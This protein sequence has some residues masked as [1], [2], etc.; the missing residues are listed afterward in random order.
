M[1]IMGVVVWCAAPMIAEA[2]PLNVRVMGAMT[3]AIRGRCLSGQ[4]PR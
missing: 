3:Q 2:D 4:G 1:E